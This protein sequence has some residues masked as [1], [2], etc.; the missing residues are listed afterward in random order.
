[1]EVVHNFVHTIA[2]IAMLIATSK[3]CSAN[4]TTKNKPKYSNTS[5][6][7]PPDLTVVANSITE[8]AQLTTFVRSGALRLARQRSPIG[9][10]E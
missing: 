10:T 5:F 6:L 7:P 4:I 9:K 1:M 2:I 3:V 8:V